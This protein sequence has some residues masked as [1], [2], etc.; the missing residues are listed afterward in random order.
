VSSDRYDNWYYVSSI[1]IWLQ[2]FRIHS[3]NRL[4]ILQNDPGEDPPKI[5]IGIFEFW[6]GKMLG[7]PTVGERADI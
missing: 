3:D 5:L 2:R 4:K 6:N 7:P 1:S